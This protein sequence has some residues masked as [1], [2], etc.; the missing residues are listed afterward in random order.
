MELTFA[1]TQPPHHTTMLWWC[2][3]GSIVA[4]VLM[5]QWLPGWKRLHETPPAPLTVAL[6]EIP[7][8][9]VPPEIVPPKPLP[10][11]AKPVAQER[12]KPVPVK[13]TPREAQPLEPVRAPILTAPPEAPVTTATPVVP[14]QKPVPPPEPPRPPPVAVAAPAPLT[15]PR[16]EAAYLRNPA[17]DYPLAAKRRGESGTVLLRVLVTPEGNPLSVAV[18]KTSGSQS[19]DEAARKAVTGWKFVPGKE[20]DKAVQAEVHVPIVFNIKNE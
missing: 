20:G 1:P 18:F 2:I 14:E 13:A 6:R 8:P 17:P 9:V 11:E 19:L 10:V 3:A 12:A 7:P 16:F 4:H 5:L 15:A